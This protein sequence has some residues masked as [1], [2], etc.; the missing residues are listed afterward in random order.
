MRN[1]SV[2]V[3]AAVVCMFG[4]AFGQSAPRLPDIPYLGAN[5]G[6]PDLG[7]NKGMWDVPRIFDMNKAEAG[8]TLN[9]DVPFTPLGKKT[10][11][12]R[13]DD[14]QKF[15]PEARCMP[16]GVPR[17]MY[18]PYPAQIFQL[19]DR[20]LF[21][22]EGGTHVWRSIFVDG[23]Q[24][25]KDINPTWL[26]D[27]IG[28]WEGDTLVVDRIAF[29]DGVWLDQEAHPHSDKLHVIERYHRVDLGHLETEVTVEDP[30]ILAKPYTMKRVSDLA[31]GE[32]IR[33]FICT[34]NNRDLSHLV[35]K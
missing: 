5:A 20:V 16:P 22:Y 15:D 21:I 29:V 27:S 31:P 32:E 23:R 35:G 24:H 14:L 30:G 10:Y 7:N 6:K 34:E 26:G 11:Q 28:H 17:M 4:P 19:P 8:V 12:E 33:E 1:R 13:Q 3:L 2:R 18:T 25:P 9:Q